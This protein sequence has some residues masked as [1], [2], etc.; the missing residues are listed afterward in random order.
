MSNRFHH[1]KSTKTSNTPGRFGL[2]WLFIVILLIVGCA[3]IRPLESAAPDAT[4]PSSEVLLAW[5][6][7]TEMGD[8]DPSQCKSLQLLANN[9]A[10]IGPCSEQGEVNPLPPH[11]AQ[12]F[13]DLV[14][15]FAPFTVE[16]DGDTLLFQGKGSTAGEARQRAILAW[17]HFA[18]G[19]L[20]TGRTSASVRSALSWMLG[21]LP[22]QPGVCEHLNVLVYGYAYADQVPCQG[23]DVQNSVGD[24]L[25]DD[26]L[27]TF[28][29]LLYQYAPFYQENNYLAGLGQAEMGE[30]EAAELAAWAEALYTRLTSQQ[31]LST[32]EPQACATPFAEVQA[33]TE[34]II[35]QT[36]A[37]YQPP[38]PGELMLLGWNPAD[39]E[40]IVAQ[41]VA[42]G[43]QFLNQCT[44][45][46]TPLADQVAQLASLSQVIPDMEFTIPGE[47]DFL[48]LDMKLTQ[49]YTPSVQLLDVDQDGNEE[50]IL[51]TQVA[52]FDGEQILF[53]VRGGVSIA[54]FATEGGWQGQVIWPISHY[55]PQSDNLLIFAPFFEDDFA[56]QVNGSAADALIYDPA[57]QVQMLTLRDDEGGTYM[58]LSHN[59]RNPLTDVRELAV[60]RWQD[61]QP[62]V[63]LRIS[64]NDWCVTANWT[65][66]ED[67]S[68]FIP[69]L[70]EPFPHCTGSFAARTFTLEDGKFV[71]QEQ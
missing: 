19:E 57:P 58:A 61:R 37:A 49:L 18:Y 17:T 23:G 54:Y 12:E 1:N 28:D 67:G 22:D 26:E 3:P 8:G 25:T 69:A 2:S 4:A 64:L 46:P 33:A 10:T 13:A 11:L 71:M 52:Y 62:E 30:A 24:W 36:V 35:T 55:V 20:A 51:H 9:R 68:I 15:R 43:E 31:I 16:T 7:Y 59:L 48:P 40:A 42:A 66:Q 38:Q 65:I 56:N 21:E 29:A 34:A 60:L 44:D 27:A 45:A 70:P 63:A 39:W 14:A 47:G 50:V 53:G 5:E 32:H 6:G 41:L